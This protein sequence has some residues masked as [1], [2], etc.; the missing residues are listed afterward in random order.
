MNYVLKSEIKDMYDAEI[1]EDKIYYKSLQKGFSLCEASKEN[2]TQKWDSN[3]K[4]VFYAITNDL[5]IYSANSEKTM[6]I[7][8]FNKKSI[9]TINR[10]FAFNNRLINNKFILGNTRKDIFIYNTTSYNESIFVNTDYSFYLLKDNFAL[11]QNKNR[12]VISCRDIENNLKLQW[13][14]DISQFGTYRDVLDG[15]CER[16]ILDTHLYKDKII[17]GISKAVIAL[18]FKTGELVWKV[19]IEEEYHPTNLL[20]KGN[21]CYIAKGVYYM[22]IDLDN[23]KK[24]FETEKK[25]IE[26]NDKKI[27]LFRESGITYHDN[28]IWYLFTDVINDPQR[29]LAS[30]APETLELQSIQPIPIYDQHRQPVFDGNRLYV[31]EDSGTLNIFE[32]E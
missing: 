13:L 14:F 10:Y 1:H 21:K 18:D 32:K 19:D 29:Y 23:G 8:R 22:V 9:S 2:L 26:Y 3:N 4:V 28:Q 7:D 17:L 31:L 24:I 5:I 30:F 25:Q 16:E 15:E 6:I 12:S 20:I 27:L 11:C